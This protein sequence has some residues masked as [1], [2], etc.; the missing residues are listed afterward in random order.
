M[1]L[2][3]IVST[4]SRTGPTNQLFNT[5]SHLCHKHEISILTL[6]QEGNDSLIN[7][8]KELNIKLIQLNQS[9]IKGIFSL[10]KLTK[11]I[12]DLNQFDVIHTQG[13]RADSLASKLDL[14]NHISTARNYPYDDYPVKF[15][16]LKGNLMAKKHL[17]IFKRIKYKIACSVSLKER[18]K[19]DTNMS[20]C[21]I[22]NGVDLSKYREQSPINR[23]KARKTL[24]IESDK[25]IFVSVGSLIPR[26]DPQSLIKGF[27]EVEEPN[28]N[29]IILGD[30]LQKKE[31]KDLAKTDGRIDFKGNVNNVVEYLR[32]SDYFISPS[33][34]E[35]LPNTVL[36]AMSVGLPVLLSEIG[37]HKEILEHDMRAG[38]LFKC[39]SPIEI[40]ELIQ[41]TLN[42]NNVV[43]SKY[44][45]N[46]IESNF[47]AEVTAGKY[48][49]Y[50]RK[51]I[52]GE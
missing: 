18:F 46:L 23:D 6:S 45:S 31:L 20:F 43:S 8:F 51:V 16:K 27:M 21:A 4:L 35:G 34:S 42:D 7:N 32:V 41:E 5:V 38:I 37:P 50:Y 17:Q 15:G 36:E 1:E 39:R 13:I 25:T 3:Y 40:K 22:Q 9:R 24:N 44:A 2:L 52:N 19:K 26:K 33:L 14:P 12:I 30:G 47:S 11:R 28:V 49:N 10:K 29:L 48:E